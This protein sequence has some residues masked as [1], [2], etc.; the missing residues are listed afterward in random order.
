MFQSFQNSYTRGYGQ[1]M[2]H[3]ITARDG[4]L[5]QLAANL[6]FQYDHQDLFPED[7]YRLGKLS[8]PNLE[9]NI[10]GTILILEKSL[11]APMAKSL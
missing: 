10:F 5:S 6:S 4:T 2:N 7:P 1:A 11:R 9:L 8:L 3:V